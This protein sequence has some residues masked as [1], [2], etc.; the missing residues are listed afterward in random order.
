MTVLAAKHQVV[1]PLFSTN[2]GGI[3]SDP[4]SVEGFDQVSVSCIV[5]E[6]F[7]GDPAEMWLQG[8]MDG[9]VWFDI[10]AKVRLQEKE[11]L[12]GQQA[13]TLAKRNITAPITTE[14]ENLAIYDVMPFDL[15]RARLWQAGTEV[16]Q[17]DCKMT[18][19]QTRRAAA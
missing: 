1:W 4:V 15:V 14:N 11:L 19:K 18:M 6:D 9:L 10:P 5:G 2:Q 12:I 17:A 16:W 7:S 8:S 13:A 3:V